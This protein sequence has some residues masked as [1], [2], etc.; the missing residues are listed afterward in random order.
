VNAEATR[1]RVEHE[2]FARLIAD[3]PFQPATNYWRAVEIAAIRPDDL[4][5]GLGLDLGC[6]DGRLTRLVLEQVGGRR[7]VGVDPDPLETRLAEMEGI[8]E[9]IHTALGDRIPEPDASFDWVFS[10]SVL[11]HIPDLAPVLTEVARLLRPDG[12]FIFTVPQETFHDCLS[13]PWLPWLSR[14]AYLEMIDQRCAHER[15]W[16]IADWRRALA[17]AG[18]ELLQARR[19]LSPRET[20]RWE[21]LSRLTAGLLYT[22]IGRRKRPI[23]MQRGLKLRGRRLGPRW[24]GSIA[25]LLAP[26]PPGPDQ[27]VG[28]CL[29]VIARPLAA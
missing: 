10:N 24:A 11:E 23:D 27:A 2:L 1:R 16:G 15:Y 20:R 22:I 28:S 29:L 9:R 21:T 5:A 18:L 13:G 14:Q 25:A 3:A 4:P 12:R 7:V 17:Q 19:Y 6:G 26:Q 8:Y